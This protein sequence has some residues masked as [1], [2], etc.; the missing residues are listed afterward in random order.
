MLKI[1]VSTE[2]CSL[3]IVSLKIKMNYLK[4][5]KENNMGV[6]SDKTC[7]CRNCFRV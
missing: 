6:T 5:K 4:K 1:K 7:L 2:F 3:C